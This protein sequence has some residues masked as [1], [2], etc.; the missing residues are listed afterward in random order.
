ML[1]A[2]PP[3]PFRRTPPSGTVIDIGF[4]PPQRVETDVDQRTSAAELARAA[5]RASVTNNSN[6][7]NPAMIATLPATVNTSDS[8]AVTSTSTAV[9]TMYTWSIS[10]GRIIACSNPETIRNTTTGTATV[11]AVPT[12]DS[13][14]GPT[15]TSRPAPSA[16]TAANIK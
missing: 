13:L 2:D 7:I 16:A 10:P 9:P 5:N 1:G 14:A 8:A 4:R 15:A 12:V 3:A 11:N 6:A